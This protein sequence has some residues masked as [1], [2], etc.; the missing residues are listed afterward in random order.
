MDG[1][2]NLNKPKNIT[3]YDAIR[4][5]KRNFN[6]SEKIGH[7][8]TLDPLAEGVL[9]ICIGK[10]TKLSRFFME[11]EKEYWAKLL[12]GTVTD[13]LD[14]EG[15]VI[16][17]KDVNVDVNDIEKV[18]KEFEGEIEQ[19]PP[20]V[21]AIKYKGKPLYKL[22][23]KGVVISPK[24]RKVYIKEIKLLKVDL[25]YVEFKVICSKGTYIR[26]LCRD[27]GEKLKCGATQAELTRLRIGPFRIED[28]VSLDEVK[29]K[30][31]ENSI[32][33]IE[34]AVGILEKWKSN[35]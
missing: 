15:K 6:F 34:K 32:I 25:P 27:I 13:T 21:S 9:I 18:L 33:P 4:F 26:A 3:S 29:E 28:S 10:A 1:I 20:S 2:I 35:L 5:I 31:L 24:P 8:G 23:R 14:L 7:A 11:L 22:Y 12:L 16:E 30:G 19:I 17:K